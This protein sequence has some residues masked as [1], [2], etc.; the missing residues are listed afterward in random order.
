MW[1][2][3]HIIVLVALA[4]SAWGVV[5]FLRGT[6]ITIDHLAPFGIVVGFLGSAGVAFEYFLWRQRWLQGWFVKRPDVRGTWRVKLQSNW[7]NPETREQIDPINCFMAVTQTYSNLQM[8]LMTPES[9]SWF[10]ADRIRPSQKGEGYEIIGVYTNQPR[11][12]LR[13]DRSEIHFGAVV[14]NTHG[15]RHFY[16]D[17]LTGEYWTERGTKGNLTLSKR[18]AKIYTRYGD[19]K[20]A[21]SSGARRK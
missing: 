7:I 16:P 11:I 12:D 3:L 1:N 15:T 10:V 20:H 5:L 13:G 17:T 4:T 21:I 6:P 9:D 2:R 14:L 18:L 8:H 19:A